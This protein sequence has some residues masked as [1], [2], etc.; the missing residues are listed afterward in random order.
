MFWFWNVAGWKY[1]NRNFFIPIVLLFT[2]HS[3]FSIVPIVYIFCQLSGR[4][5]KF[6]QFNLPNCLHIILHFF[7]RTSTTATK[8]QKTNTLNMLFWLINRRRLWKSNTATYF[9]VA[10]N[11]MCYAIKCRPPNRNF[12]VLN[13]DCWHF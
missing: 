8:K 13:C 5:D 7:L 10:V 3:T 1:Y 2:I 9:S 6:P 12:C 4:F 11:Y